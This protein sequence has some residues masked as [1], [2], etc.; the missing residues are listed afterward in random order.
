MRDWRRLSVTPTEELDAIFGTGKEAPPPPPPPTPPAPS[1]PPPS[2]PPSPPPQQP[3]G[4]TTL[5]ATALQ[6]GYRPSRRSL[7]GAG[8]L[9]LQPLA[10]AANPNDNRLPPGARMLRVAEV[11]YVMENQML[12][13]AAL[14][15]QERL[16]TGRAISRTDLSLSI[17]ILVKNSELEKISSAGD[18]VGALRGIARFCEL[19]AGRPLV[20]EEYEAIARQYSAARDGL[21]S[22]FESLSPQDQE[23]S[24]SLVRKMRAEDE[25]R[26]REA[27]AE[28]AA[29]QP[30][31][32]Q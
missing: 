17:S 30:A 5:A 15:E 14:S 31:A 26:M 9:V 8:A 23:R 3:L 21:Q 25:A 19:G 32:V 18:A 16:E 4:S 13:A 7:L 27:M 11:T 24:R 6:L 28:D 20:K 12:E 10:V 29:A 1:A 2:P 22:A